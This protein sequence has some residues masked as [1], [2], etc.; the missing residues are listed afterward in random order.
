MLDKTLRTRAGENTDM[1][2][3][4]CYVNINE[5]ILREKESKTIY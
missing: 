2:K 3:Q 5:F 1:D 4:K